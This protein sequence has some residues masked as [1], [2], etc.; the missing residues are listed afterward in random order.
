MLSCRP[1]VL[2]LG[3][4]SIDNSNKRYNF[5]KKK[6]VVANLIIVANLRDAFSSSL[7]IS[8]F[9]STSNRSPKLQY[10]CVKGNCKLTKKKKN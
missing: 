4:G 9:L 3:Y 2:T 8:S 5:D 10:E 7:L 1:R 6:K